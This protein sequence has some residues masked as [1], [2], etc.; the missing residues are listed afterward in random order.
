MI[1]IRNNSNVNRGLIG[2]FDVTGGRAV[3]G[4]SPSPLSRKREKTAGQAGSSYSI[5]VQMY[6]KKGGSSPAQLLALSR[7]TIGE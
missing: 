3:M 1:I 5:E 4:R 6:N 2:L 7:Q